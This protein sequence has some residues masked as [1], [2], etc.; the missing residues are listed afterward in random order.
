[1]NAA[2]IPVKSL[3]HAKSRLGA[4]LS[5][6]ERETLALWMLDHVLDVLLQCREIDKV[7]LACSDDAVIAR[8]YCR[9]KLSFLPDFGNL[10]ET[11][12]EAGRLLHRQ[13]FSSMLFLFGDLPLLSPRDIERA[14]LAAQK[15][16]VLFMPDRHGMGTN[17][18]LSALPMEFAAQFG[19]HSLERHIAAA[20]K[21]G[22]PHKLL[23]TRG[24]GS[25]IDTPQ[26]LEELFFESAQASG[27]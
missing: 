21:A 7:F 24:F 5:P 10:N 9:K 14:L 2:V 19:N 13:G 8:E 15:C 27:I 11:A 3:V 4:V 23:K 16:P 12:E 26:D 25:D 6:E 22:F 18:F 17:G 1:M 20:Q